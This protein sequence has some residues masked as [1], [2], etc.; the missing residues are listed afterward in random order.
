E[1]SYLQRVANFENV[2]LLRTVSKLG[3]AGIR[4]GALIGPR[5]WMRELDKLRLPYNINVLTQ[6][7][8]AFAMQNYPVFER[9]A[10]QLRMERERLYKNLGALEGLKAYPSHANF[11]LFRLDY[12]VA[13]TVHAELKSQRILLKNVSHAS[14]LLAACLRVTVGAPDENR[15]FLTALQSILAE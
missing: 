2:L 4:L 9:Q 6:A 8:M 13:D 14:P 11:I 7:T 10:Q 3:L 12:Y 5:A 1:A 15:I